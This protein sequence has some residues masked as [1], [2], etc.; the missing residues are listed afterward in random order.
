MPKPMQVRFIHAA[1]L[2]LG[3]EQYNLQARF[4]DFAKAY[5][6]MVEHAVAVQADFVLIAGDLFHKAHTDAWT[7]KQATAGLEQLR[8]AGVPVVAIEGNH[9]AQHMRKHLSWMEFLCDQDLLTLLDLDRAPN[10]YR[11]FV[12]FDPT[13][14]RGS[15]L[16][17]AGV[18][19]YGMKYYGVSTARILDELSGEIE[20]GEGGYTGLLLHAGLQGQV[21]HLHGG[22]TPAELEPL[23]GRVD[24]LALGHIHKRLMKDEW[25]FNPGSTEVNSMEEMDWPHGFFQVEVDTEKNPPHTVRPVE[26]PTLRPFRRISV[27]AEGINSLEEFVARAEDRIAAARSIPERA[28]VELHLGGVAEF[29]RQ[30]VPLERLKTEIETRFSPL[31]VRVRNALVPPGVLPQRRG[32]RVSR[33]ELER[34]IVEQLVRQH[35]EHR[36]RAAAWARLILDV[37]NMA[38]E[39]DLAASI[40]DHIQAAIRAMPGAE[41]SAET[42]TEAAEPVALLAELGEGQLALEAG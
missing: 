36:D 22:L 33:Q 40:A 26:T 24:Y 20:P 23:R 13:T 31:A 18:R 28:V 6:A 4:N 16:D 11:S 3:Y 9:D 42:G 27:G 8:R 39:K 7:L 30:D 41:T 35:A 37:K 14:R 2:H 19:I 21:P 5:F 15:Y 12:P 38:V 1:D 29:R 10:G 25:V 32:E 34:E 17:L